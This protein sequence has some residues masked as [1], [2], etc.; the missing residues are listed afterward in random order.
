MISITFFPFFFYINASA[1]FWNYFIC[2]PMLEIG[3]R[4]ETGIAISIIE[5]AVSL[6]TLISLHAV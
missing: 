3:T 6:N 2:G 4:N 5:E 1:A